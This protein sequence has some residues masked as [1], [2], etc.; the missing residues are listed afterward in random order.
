[1]AS[2]LARLLNSFIEMQQQEEANSKKLEIQIKSR[3]KSASYRKI[4]LEGLGNKNRMVRRRGTR[5]TRRTL[6]TKNI[7][8]DIEGLMEK[9]SEEIRQIELS[10]KGAFSKQSASAKKTCP[11][12]R[13]AWERFTDEGVQQSIIRSSVQAAFNSHTRRY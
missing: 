4:S 9:L 6:V 1:M 5:V 10:K 8:E 12:A 3:M 7:K 13:S 2:G 11:L